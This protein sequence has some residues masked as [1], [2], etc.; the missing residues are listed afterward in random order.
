MGFKK[1]VIL[2]AVF[3]ALVA[4]YM[5]D[6]KRILKNETAKEQ[7]SRLVTVAKADVTGLDID[8]RGEKLRIAKDG[9]HWKLTAPVNARVADTA[10]D[11]MLTQL[12]SARRGDPFDAADSRLAEYGLARPAVTVEVKA[13]AKNFAG[14]VDFGSNTTD[15]Q[16]LYAR[17]GG[18]G[19]VF[20]VP[21]AVLT[22]LTQPLDQIRDKRIVPAEM[23]SAT[24]FQIDDNGRKLAA[25]KKDGQW[26]LTEPVRMKGDDMQIRQFLGQIGGTEAKDFLDTPTLDLAPLGLKAPKWRGT[27]VVADGATTRSIGL[28]F[29]DANTSPATSLYAKCDADPYVMRIGSALASKI[30]V[31]AET[32]RDKTLFTMK[33]QDVGSLV[34]SVH[35]RPLYLDRDSG[36]QWRI[37]GEADTPVDQ[38]KIARTLTLLLDLK[39]TRFYDKAEAPALDLM[40]L[41][42]PMLLARVASRDRTATET[43][44][45]GIKA[46]GDFVWARLV[47]TDQIVG[48]DWTKPGSFFLTRDDVIQRDLFGF[49]EAAAKTITI[50]D[51]GKTTMTL[52]REKG[53]WEGTSPVGTKV[54]IDGARVEAFL[55]AMLRLQWQRRLD[56]RVEGDRVLIQTQR[57]NPPVRRIAV[58]NTAGKPLGS[59]AQGGD[60]EQLSY[61]A[62][63]GLYYTVERQ[64]M[65]DFT[66]AM[67]QL[68]SNLQ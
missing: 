51:E 26:M 7:Q 54:K 42:K 64:K 67:K 41:T 43:L 61:L 14:Q 37:R 34:L 33:A 44:E 58:L 45:T 18:R 53:G 49:E 10:V 30:H 5:W 66:N 55:D 27:F 13:A 39:A 32:L 1:I 2:A 17:T 46:Q 65:D 8:R 21:A 47:N 57:L 36:G 22:P 40:G 59:F 29:G 50:S 15:G 12:D 11:N 25:V 19:Q 56:P 52:T 48:L 28:A 31:N 24:A 3:A 62:T 20:T 35:G 16:H 68:V 60:T 4:A 23:S 6:Q 9:N 63:G 38:G